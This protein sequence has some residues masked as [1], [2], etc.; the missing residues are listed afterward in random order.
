MREHIIS[1]FVHVHLLRRCCQ[2]VQRMN[3]ES[4]INCLDPHTCSLHRI[5][6]NSFE[7]SYFLIVEVSKKK[8]KIKFKSTHVMSWINHMQGNWIWSSWFFPNFSTTTHL[9]K[10]TFHLFNI[11]ETFVISLVLPFEKFSGQE[12][13]LLMGH[14]P[15]SSVERS[16]TVDQSGPATHLVWHNVANIV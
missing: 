1:T 10:R 6:Y 15:I 3:F 12:Q 16:P 14:K 7:K 9:L 8:E 5:V 13:G 2:H 11:V 4:S